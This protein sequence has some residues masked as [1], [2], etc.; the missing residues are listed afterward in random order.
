M[1]HSAHSHATTIKIKNKHLWPYTKYNNI[2]LNYRQHGWPKLSNPMKLLTLSS[3]EKIL[4]KIKPFNIESM[5]PK[6]WPAT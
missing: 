2:C 6:Q 1:Y 3:M 5:M 4:F